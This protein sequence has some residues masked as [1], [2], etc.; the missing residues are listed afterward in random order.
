MSENPAKDTFALQ[1][2]QALQDLQK[3]QKE[4]NYDSCLKCE[5]FFECPVRKSYVSAVYK[6]MNKGEQGGFEF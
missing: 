1:L 6:S 2:D 5:K 4:R 3:C